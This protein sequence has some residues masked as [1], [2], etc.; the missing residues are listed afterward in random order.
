M[1]AHDCFQ[2]QWALQKVVIVHMTR[3]C[4]VLRVRCHARMDL[5]QN[6]DVCVTL[7][8]F[9]ELCSHTSHTMTANQRGDARVMI[10]RPFDVPFHTGLILG[11]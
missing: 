4:M 10:H 1:N 11:T 3:A 6:C 5:R 7:E 9:E 8:K 2:S